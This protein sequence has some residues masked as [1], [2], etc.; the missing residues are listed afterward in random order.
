M[1]VR[2]RGVKNPEEAGLYR[3]TW[4][5]VPTADRPALPEGEYYHHQLIGL[6]V[7]SDEGRELGTL[8]DILET[9]ANEVYVVRDANG[10]EVLL[11]AISPVILDISLADRQIR[12]HLLD[13]LI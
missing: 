5:Y 8:V 6:N 13:G 11:P 10:D 3:N 2:F 1:L 12:V 7:I 9:G 4:V